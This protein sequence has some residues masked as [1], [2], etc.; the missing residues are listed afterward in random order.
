M[1][2][3]ALGAQHA[4]GFGIAQAYGPNSSATVNITGL[5]SQEL[6]EAL[7]AAGEAQQAAI[8][9]LSRELD[10]SQN[11]VR[12]FFKILS[13]GDIPT[14]K[15][16]ST[17]EEIAQRHRKMLERLSALDPEDSGTKALIEEARATLGLAESTEA[18]DRADDLL[19]NAE[20]LDVQGI[21][22]AEALER[23]AE[24]AVSRKRRSAAATRAERGELSL[25]RLDYLQSSQHFKA[26]AELVTRDTTELRVS[27]LN[28][29]AWALG[30]YGCIRGDNAV[31]AQAV[32][33]YQTTL[34]QIV[35]EQLPI[36]WAKTQNELGLV[37]MKLG[38]RE[39]GKARLQEAEAAVREA[40]KERTRE[41]TPREWAKTQNSLGIVL[42][43]LGDRSSG[44]ALL[45]SAETAF[46]KAL[47]EQTRDREPLERARTQYNL[48]FVLSRIGERESGTVRLKDAETAFRECLK[49]ITR[50]RAP[51]DWAA[52]QE[53]LGNV[54]TALS[55][56]EIGTKPLAEVVSQ[57]QQA[58]TAF[59]EALKERI[60]E[61]VPLLWA[62]TQNNL[63][64]VLWELFPYR[65]AACRQEAEAAYREALKEYTRERDPLRWATIQHNLGKVLSIHRPEEAVT[66][67]REA[68]KE[69]TRQR[70]PMHWAVTQVSLASLLQELGER[71]DDQA[72]LEEAVAAY[73]EILAAFTP[74]ELPALRRD[75]QKNL[76]EVL[77]ILGQRE[78]G[79]ARLK[80]ATAVFREL[81]ADT[82]SEETEED[83]DDVMQIL[84]ERD[85]LG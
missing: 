14:N 78:S 68:L 71:E 74:G 2:D 81:L 47:E 1:N 63:G 84:R 85:G 83:L 77:K 25:T 53:M 27:Y 56:R 8:S 60:R 80:E 22:A 6:Q 18:Y 12:G 57:L 59:R 79:T 65:G 58:E 41:R 30:E 33:V 62:T 23:E 42:M 48:G 19:A 28:S 38:E 61:R 10:T 5:T 70:T 64:N 35:R 21:R 37:L 9:S 3:Q 31:L 40:L 24:E 7:R 52:V 69:R 32:D 51:L 82:P 49:E 46:R 45:E 50:E 29:Y 39:T 66:A 73:R 72:R 67:Y 26:A 20:A 43:L 13:A 34:R 76:G 55:R 4:Q 54:L 36:M 16:L 44:T 11:A 15:L 75:V 17:L